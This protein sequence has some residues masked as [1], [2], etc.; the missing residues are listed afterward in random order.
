MRP[1]L[2]AL[3]LVGAL[4]CGGA[5][6]RPASWSYIHAAIIRP[7]CATISCHSDENAQAGLRLH[8][9]EAA[10]SILVGRSCDGPPF[11]EQAPGNYVVPGDPAR[12]QLMHLIIGEEVPRAM[13]PDRLL[14]APDVD[15]IE[16]WILE[17]A[18]CN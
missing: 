6:D 9:R 13:P 4:A 17:G 10:Y 8:T 12:S 5:D 15:L 11:D 2:V 3:G 1:Y 14:P 18:P 7:S 16:T